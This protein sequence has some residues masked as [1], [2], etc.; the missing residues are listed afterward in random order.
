MSVF[1]LDFLGV[2]LVGWPVFLQQRDG[3][4]ELSKIELWSASSLLINRR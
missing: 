3:L 2:R 1:L 4:L